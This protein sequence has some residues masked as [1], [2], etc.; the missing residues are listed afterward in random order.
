MLP[1][2]SAHLPLK[3]APS[4]PKQRCKYKGGA[5]GPIALCA[6][7]LGN[8][9]VVEPVGAARFQPS[10]L[11]LP[12]GRLAR[13][14]APAAS[15][16][17]SRLPPPPPPPLVPPSSM[18]LRFPYAPPHHSAAH[19][20]SAHPCPQS[21]PW[22]GETTLLSTPGCTQMQR[23]RRQAAACPTQSLEPSRSS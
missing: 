21:R 6:P 15:S 7:P 19:L 17:P 23:R 10:P 14:A 3:T 22:R 20:H 11:H 8:V 9:R 18:L 4:V 5:V 16:V 13:P 12:R 2:A 1:F